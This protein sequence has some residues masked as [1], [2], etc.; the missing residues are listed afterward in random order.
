MSTVR[1]RVIDEPAEV[2]V[3]IVV[4]EVIVDE[5]KVK[6]QLNWSSV[7]VLGIDCGN[8]LLGLENS[9]LLVASRPR[10]T[11]DSVT[12]FLATEL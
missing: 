5:S 6:Q 11:T 8:H 9:A 3:V 12:F 4:V 7:S 10:C 2:T 1:V